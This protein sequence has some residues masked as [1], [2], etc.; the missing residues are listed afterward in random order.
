M[1]S[2]FQNLN[3]N[4]KEVFSSQDSRY[5]LFTALKFTA[6][7][8][9]S[10]MIV[11]YLLWTIMEMNFNFFVANGF[12]QDNGVFYDTMFM[13][14]SQYIVYFSVMLIMVFM[15]GLFTSYLAL[16]AF[17]HIEEHTFDLIED[18]DSQL[19]ISGLNRNKL[20]YQV[21]R[22][23]FKYIQICVKNEKAPEFKLPKQI[24]ELKSPPLDKVFLFQ[25]IMI[26][27]I[28][29]LGTSMLLFS[30]THELYEEIVAGGFDLL[31]SNQ[32]VSTYLDAQEGIILNIY[33]LSTIAN[34]MAYIYISRNIIKTVD[35]V[36][37]G[38]AR[39]MVKVIK[40]HHHIR[41]V[42][43]SGDPGQGIAKV[44]NA[45]LDDIFPPEE[46]NR[47]FDQAITDTIQQMDTEYEPVFNSLDELNQEKLEEGKDYATLERSE[48]SVLNML[49]SG[50]PI[51]PS[52]ITKT[53]K[54]ENKAIEKLETD[55]FN[56]EQKKLK[57]TS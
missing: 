4:L 5:F 31:S 22:V 52:E 19:I 24:E 20:I 39:D 13:N 18:I 38:I 28:I 51:L 3:R 34:I 15:L 6:V 23:F 32:I 53:I 33:S 30:F 8:L 12:T 56:E 44:L 27:G 37:Y 10:S 50:P 55:L 2:F 36:S 16:R 49:M 43:R 46:D 40:G 7:P 9:I 42:P 29:C 47:S 21:S 1:G 17:D 14:I 25:Y 48:S 57:K 11:F 35:G 54:D 26:V 45:V 41:L